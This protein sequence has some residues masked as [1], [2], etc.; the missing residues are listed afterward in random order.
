[1]RQRVLIV[2]DQC[3]RL[4]APL[5]AAFPDVAFDAVPSPADAVPFCAEATAIISLAHTISAEMIAAAPKLRWI[6][7]LTTG[8]DHLRTLP[9]ADEVIITSARGLSAGPVSEF[10]MMYLLAFVKRLPEILANQRKS[11]WTHTRGNT[12]NG[13]TLTIVGAGAI[14][15]RLAQ[16]AAVFGMR[17][18]GVSAGRTEAPG[19]DAILPRE[20]LPEAA[21]QADFLVVLVPQTDATR[22][23]ID[24][25]VLAAMKPSAY[26]IN[27]A[28]GGVIDADAVVAALREGRLAGAALDVFAPEPMPAGSPFWAMENVIVSPH[29]AGDSWEIYETAVPLMSTNLQAMIDDRPDHLINVVP[30]KA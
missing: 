3:E 4:R 20:R 12:L 25:R 14:S 7:A 28:R 24:A 15:E 10:V 17:V 18:I 26:L 30:R 8:T 5:A 21:A 23:L 27:V 11:F 6:G 22:N 9:I 16:R 13:R 1:V 19:F 2:D 29:A